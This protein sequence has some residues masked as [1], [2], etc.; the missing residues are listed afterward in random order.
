MSD[1]FPGWTPR[2][3]INELNRITPIMEQRRARGLTIEDHI[4]RQKNLHRALWR[5]LRKAPVPVLERE[6]Q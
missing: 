3:M 2:E 5:E 4:A 1:L 6:R